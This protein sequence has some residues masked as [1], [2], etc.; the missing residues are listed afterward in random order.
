MQ[1][2]VDD[3][4]VHD[5]FNNINLPNINDDADNFSVYDKSVKKDE[6]VNIVK[7]LQEIAKKYYQEH[8]SHKACR[9]CYI[10]NSSCT[11]RRK[12]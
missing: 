12:N 11:K 9:L 1:I 6:V 7:R 4:S 2:D 5:N 3:I 8:T 10:G